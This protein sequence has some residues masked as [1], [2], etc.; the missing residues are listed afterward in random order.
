[1]AIL[2]GCQRTTVAILMNHLLFNM[3]MGKKRWKHGSKI[4]LDPL[5][6]QACILEGII[7][8]LII[9]AGPM[10]NKNT[11]F[12]W[13]LTQFNQQLSKKNGIQPLV[14]PPKVPQ[15]QSPLAWEKFFTG[16]TSNSNNSVWN[17][18]SISSYF[19]SSTCLSSFTS[20]FFCSYIIIYLRATRN[21]DVRIV[22][23][24]VL[25]PQVM[26]FQSR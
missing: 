3:F 12:S 8:H 5:R 7:A 23:Q 25:I 18:H 6:L 24:L 22:F 20:T 21:Q 16:Y 2:K 15:F 9:N 4:W 17:I 26:R 1:M 13:R 11:V 14:M 10:I 19:G